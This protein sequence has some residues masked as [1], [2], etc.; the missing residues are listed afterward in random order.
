V[1]D[2]AVTPVPGVPAVPPAPAA[3]PEA[4]R[5]PTLYERRRARIQRRFGAAYFVLAVVVGIAIGMA[6][7][8]VDR[9]GGTHAAWSHY[10]PTA[11]GLQ[12]AQQIANFVAGSYRLNGQPF[13]SALAAPPEVEPSAGQN[14][15]IY[16]AAIRTGLADEKPQDV[17]FVKTDHAIV[18]YFNGTGQSGTIPGTQSIQR[19]ALLRRQI[20]ETSLYTFK[21]VDGINAVIAFPPPTVGS[22]GKPLARAVLLQKSDFSQQ[23]GK[24]LFET[25]PP[26]RV[27]TP[28]VKLDPSELAAISK[29]R[30][31]QYDFQAL[32]NET[33]LLVLTPVA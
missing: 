29:M 32:P 7:V 27:E 19:G 6:I 15:P 18:Y 30:F 10:K 23:L 28:L 14:V 2:D 17:Q 5:K 4:Q 31:L 22:D 13:T 20:L 33:A 1:A 3:A 24:P 9:S 21:Y 12:G 8:L 11:H 16:A 26:R 25:L